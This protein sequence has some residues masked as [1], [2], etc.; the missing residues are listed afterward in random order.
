MSHSLIDCSESEIKLGQ[1]IVC[2]KQVD[3]DMQV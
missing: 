3:V 2:I 1:C